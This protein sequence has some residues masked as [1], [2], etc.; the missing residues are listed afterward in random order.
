MLA[1]IRRAYRELFEI[2]PPWTPL[3]LH[4]RALARYIDA[5]ASHVLN[6]VGGREIRVLD[7]GCGDMPYRAI[8]ERDA[9]CTRYDG[10]DIPSAST[11]A[12]VAIDPDSQL[13]S[14]ASE[15]YDLIVSFQ[16]LEHVLRPMAL[17][18]ECLRVLRQGGILFVTLPFL[19]E[20][21]G[22][23]RDFRRWT[24]EGIAEDLAAMGFASVT[25]EPIETD[26]QSLV[27]M[28]EAYVA[29]NLGY[30]WTKPL[31]LA[32]N[33]TALAVD[34]LKPSNNYR[35]LPLTIAATGRKGS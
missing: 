33:A 21:H 7:V 12:T 32:L 4:H 16:A 35:V 11:R 23:P 20:Y 18:R 6:S 3:H 25:A 28:G 5:R 26:L 10:A 9:R 29:R 13:V 19:F 22:V 27:V 34:R 24:H 30:V 14:A 15:S 2:S 8:F 1:H 17:L 31:F